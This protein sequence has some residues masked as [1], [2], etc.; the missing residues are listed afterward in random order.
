MSKRKL[1]RL[2]QNEPIVYVTWLGRM[3]GPGN[4]KLHQSKHQELP[5]L[6]QYFY[7][8]NMRLF[9][10]DREDPNTML[11]LQYDLLDS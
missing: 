2:G 8:K 10:I 11:N 3:E 6:W 5:V 4:G 9:K 7:M 1:L